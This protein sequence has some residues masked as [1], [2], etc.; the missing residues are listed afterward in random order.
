MKR[1]QTLRLNYRNEAETNLE[2][3]T[4]R[5]EIG[6]NNGWLQAILWYME[7]YTY[8]RRGYDGRSLNKVAPVGDGLIYPTDP[9]CCG[10]F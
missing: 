7:L 2:V 3:V 1:E 6:T 8:C 5:L 4:T 9:N 10:S